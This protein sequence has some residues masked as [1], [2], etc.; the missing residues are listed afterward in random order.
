MDENLEIP[1]M[2]EKDILKM[3]LKVCKK[4]F[5]LRRLIMKIKESEIVQIT[6]LKIQENWFSHL[7]T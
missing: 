7:F 3:F 2:S 4:A 1:R 5:Q 6:K